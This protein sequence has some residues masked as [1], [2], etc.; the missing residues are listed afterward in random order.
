MQESFAVAT[1][2]VCECYAVTI[3]RLWPN[4]RFVG[5]RHVL[6]VVEAIIRAIRSGGCRAIAI[7]RSCFNNCPFPMKDGFEWKC[8]GNCDYCGGAFHKTSSAH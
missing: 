5:Q 7:T 6:A 8:G 4:I 2:E 3:I 1:T